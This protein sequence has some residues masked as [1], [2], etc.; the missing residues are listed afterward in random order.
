MSLGQVVGVQ[1]VI[2]LIHR[3][4]QQIP[5]IVTHELSDPGSTKGRFVIV[6]L[7]EL[8]QYL[9]VNTRCLCMSV[10]APTEGRR[11]P[12]TSRHSM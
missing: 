12:L 10:F 4:V 5:W 9:P 3:A 7:V 1:G 8:L 2:V 11:S 6:S